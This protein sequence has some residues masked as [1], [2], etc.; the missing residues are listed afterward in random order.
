MDSAEIV[1]SISELLPQLE[2][3]VTEDL[4]RVFIPVLDDSI[5]LSSNRV[6][7]L[8]AIFGPRGERAI[9]F[10][11][12]DDEDLWPFILTAD[13]VVYPPAPTSTV[14]DSPIEIEISNAPPLVAYSEMTRDALGYAQACESPGVINVDGITGLE[15]LLR[16]FI[17][18][19]TRLGMRPAKAAACWLRARAALGGES[20]LGEY[21]PDSAWEEL[22]AQARTIHITYQS[23][24]AVDDPSNLAA[25]DFGEITP[26]LTFDRVDEEL[27][28]SWKRWV[29]ITPPRFAQILLD[30]LDDPQAEMTLYPDGGG[31]VV[32]RVMADGGCVGVLQ[33]GMS[34]A[35]DQFSLDEIRIEG[36]GKGTGLFQRL[37]YNMEELAKALGFSAVHTRATG[38]GSYA[39]AALGYPKDPETRTRLNR[40]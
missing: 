7:R 24:A 32:L 20:L 18:G 5:N 3:S 21:R 22:C 25:A 11:V 19:A 16:C 9:E 34:F 37:L 23:E 10:T 31:E 15:L 27:V 6:L 13:D 39:L 28:A 26:R 12:V 38:I 1:K 30:G 8:Q 36:T 35:N 4:I 14:L 40:R 17:M 33:L 2:V 29:P